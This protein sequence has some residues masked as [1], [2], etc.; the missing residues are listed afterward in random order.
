MPR[1]PQSGQCHGLMMD[2]EQTLT[3]L[4]SLLLASLLAML[5]FVQLCMAGAVNAAENG[6]KAL[7]LG[8]V[9]VDGQ[10]ALRL[11]VETITPA[12]VKL[13]LLSAP[14]RLVID[15]HDVVWQIDSLPKKGRLDRSPATAYRFASQSQGLDGLSSRWTHQLHHFRAFA[16]PPNK[17]GHRLVIDMADNGRT[18]FQVAAAALRDSKPIQF[19]GS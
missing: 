12:T 14:Y 18:A 16:L 8:S 9:S 10:S 3:R 2:K 4:T 7:R 11:V 6:L 19:G 15:M 5:V 13:S 17:G 1:L